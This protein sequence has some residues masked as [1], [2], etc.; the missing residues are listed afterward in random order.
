MKDAEWIADLL[1]H[2]LLKASFIPSTPQ[3]DLRELTRYC[4]SLTEER[5]R[6]V[7]RLQ[8]T[9]EDTN[10]KLGDVISDVLGKAGRL[11]LEAV[12]DGESDAKRL[13]ALAQGRV[14]ARRTWSGPCRG[15]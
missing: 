15:M 13:A 4:V 10:L 6:T 1:Q 8:K 2:G 3:R 5:T 14:R 7:N 9:L 12:R 11:M